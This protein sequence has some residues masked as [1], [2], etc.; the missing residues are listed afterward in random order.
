[1]RN[2]SKAGFSTRSV[3]AGEE[4][5]KYA[6][7]LIHPIAQTATYVFDTLG[8]FEA[9]K[10][11]HSHSFEY[12]RYG[13]PTQQAAENKI[14]ALEGAEA[15]LLFS[16]GMGAVS[17]SL[18][19]L[20]EGGK[21][22]IV[23]GDCYRMTVRFCRIMAKFGVQISIVDAWDWEGLERELRPETTLVFTES[24]TNPHLR[25]VDLERLVAVAHGHGLD[26]LVDSTFATPVNIRPLEYGVD[27][28]VHS[29]TKYL[30]GHNDLVA[31]GVFGSSELV[32]G[33]RE[34]QRVTGPITDPFTAFLLIRGL[35]TLA[36]RVERQ[37]ANA[38]ALARFLEQH[39]RI[40][41][42]YYPGLPSHPDHEVAARQMTGFGGVV[43]FEVD[44][45]LESTR[46][47]VDALSIPYLAPSLGGVESLATHPAT[48]SFYGLTRE[49]RLRM[50][51]TDE[52]VRY[53]A[54]IEDA[55]ELLED[56]DQA[57][58]QR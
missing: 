30:G 23:L 14:A 49:E 54:G 48:M 5:G 1:M 15:G 55:K 20:L 4:R 19:A 37:N 45:D 31:G 33:I 25:V 41:R 12:G 53:A 27:L 42:V 50:G 18:L 52:L 24:P 40:R 10:A 47:V 6:G 29:A 13:N 22:M 21:H 44:G 17:T 11:G 16:S 39:S 56:L 36:L 46:R 34:F 58:A 38:L 32:G 7:S 51:I 8:D 35:K 3:H 26:V 57:L 2:Y 28:V 43:S 9:F